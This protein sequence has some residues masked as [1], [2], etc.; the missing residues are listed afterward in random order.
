MHRDA[1][2]STW[3]RNGRRPQGWWIFESGVRYPGYAVER[4][5]LFERGLLGEEEARELAAWW[6]EE[7]T[8]AQGP[9]FTL[10]LGPAS[11]LYGAA[12]RRELYREI[13]IPASLV[14]Q[15]SKEY[16]RRSRTI[17][18]LQAV[19]TNEPRGEKSAAGL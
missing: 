8:K 7:F 9:G 3:A 2:M 16:R 18:D 14:R 5:W 10:C 11:F 13:D 1:I 15:W 17:S 4:S 12:A 6:R 19:T